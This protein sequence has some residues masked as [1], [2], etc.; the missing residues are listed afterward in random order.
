MTYESALEYGRMILPE[1]GPVVP[2]TPEAS[3][4]ATPE[5]SPA[6]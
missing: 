2:A 3:P 1:G 6:A 5:A 4:A